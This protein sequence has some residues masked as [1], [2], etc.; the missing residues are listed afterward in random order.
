MNSLL[1]ELLT[2]KCNYDSSNN[3]NF[4]FDFK[5]FNDTLTSPISAPIIYA[6]QVELLNPGKL[7]TTD[8]YTK[9]FTNNI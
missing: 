5:K 7:N 3:Y 8:I 1:S 4:Q 9:N 2:I 6:I